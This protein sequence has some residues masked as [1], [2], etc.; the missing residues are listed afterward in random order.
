MIEISSSKIVQ[1]I[2]QSREAGPAVPELRAFLEALNEDEAASLVAL[3]WVGRGSFE[4]E[5]FDAA[6]ATARAEATAP[7]ADYL[8]GVPGL[9]E[10]LEAGME[11]M[12]LDVTGEE[13]DLL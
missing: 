12:G 13:E 2:Y 1:I 10:Y 7:L 3:M 9:P 11:A 6:V 5:D 4:P 8:A